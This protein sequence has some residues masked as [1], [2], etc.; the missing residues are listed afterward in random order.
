M[1]SAYRN[2]LPAWCLYSDSSKLIESFVI[3]KA[4]SAEQGYQL[5]QLTNPA[6]V[7][8][9]GLL[10]MDMDSTAITMSVLMK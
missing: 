1:L 7:N 10:L 4:F 9:A 8:E 6:N 2:Y 5:V 3:A